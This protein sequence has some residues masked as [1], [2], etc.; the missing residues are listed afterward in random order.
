MNRT[1]PPL[2]AALTLLSGAA[3]AQD[4]E[5]LVLMGRIAGE[6]GPSLIVMEEGRFASVTAVRDVGLG[7]EGPD[8]CLVTLPEE[9]VVLPGLTDGHAHLLGIGLR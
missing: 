1:V 7:A 3:A 5:S 9:A 8:A 6:E 2:A 4:C